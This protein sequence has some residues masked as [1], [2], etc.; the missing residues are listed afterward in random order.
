MFAIDHA[1]TALLIKRGFPSEPIIPMLLSVQL[2]EL[3]WAAL[4]LLGIEQT[5]T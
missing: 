1:A 3:I 4:N 2:L 5:T